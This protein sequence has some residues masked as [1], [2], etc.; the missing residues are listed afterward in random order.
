MKVTIAK[1][2]LSLATS[3]M[4][5]AITERS[6]AQI[7]LRAENGS[8][9][10]AAT[11]RILAVYSH[12]ESNV[13]Q[14]GTVFVPARL[15]SDVVKELPEGEVCIVQDGAYIIITAGANSS[16]TMKIPVIDDLNWREPP[17]IGENFVA[18]SSDIPADKLSYLIEQVQFCVAAD[19]PRNY[20]SVAFLHKPKNGTC[21]MVGTDGFRLSYSEADIP[22]PEKFL[23]NGV[24][25]SKRAIT[26][27]H[28]M[29]GEGFETVKLSISAD[30]TTLVSEVPGY[31][32]FVRLSAVKYPNYMGVLPSSDHTGVVVS[33]PELQ[34][35]AKRV[36]LAA[37][38]SRALQLCFSNSSLTLNSKTMGSSE[39]RETVPLEEYQ[40]P[41]FDVV[42]NGKFLSDVFQT[43]TSENLLL[44]F[45]AE[46]E[47]PVVIVPRTE[48]MDCHSKHVLV[49][50]K[51]ND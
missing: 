10:V 9:Q 35:I 8:L 41:R 28:R 18:N 16:F 25:L 44:Q 36:L 21:R 7:G 17:T 11:D 24:C 26:E 33:R 38:K 15:F 14:P 2:S 3:R 46:G 47:E 23:E 50:I 22:M 51:Q 13:E 45:N 49:P 43:T 19:S 5:G 30:E 29:C 37:D 6:L 48:P 31:T 42:I 34:S 4:Q 27:I 39:G 20:G 12:L 1:G 32:I 40:G